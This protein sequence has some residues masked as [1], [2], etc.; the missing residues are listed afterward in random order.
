[1]RTAVLLPLVAALLMALVSV[2]VWRRLRARRDDRHIIA[3][4]DRVLA[5][6][7]A[8]L[9]KT[10]RADPLRFRTAERVQVDGLALGWGLRPGRVQLVRTVRAATKAGYR[11]RLR[12]FARALGGRTIVRSVD[13]EVRRS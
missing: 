4:L 5:Q 9:K 10:R 8:E 11:L 7:S 2:L 3:A 6:D 13:V 1:M 12:A